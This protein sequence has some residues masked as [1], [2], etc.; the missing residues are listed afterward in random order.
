M[1]CSVNTRS[2]FTTLTQM[3]ISV[4]WHGISQ[5]THLMSSKH[6]DARLSQPSG[7]RR[8]TVL[9]SDGEAG[10]RSSHTP[11]NMASAKQAIDF[12]IK[13]IKKYLRFAT[14]ALLRCSNG[15]LY[16]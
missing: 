4:E 3:R 16:L 13:Y 12:A 9:T 15:Q 5:C 8:R 14:V 11:V 2:Q 7:S 1:A 10:I 6:G